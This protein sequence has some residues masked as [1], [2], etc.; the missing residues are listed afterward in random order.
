[1][2]LAINKQVKRVYKTV[3]T[4]SSIGI[5]VQIIDFGIQFKIDWQTKEKVVSE[6][7]G[8]PILQQH[9]WIVFETPE[10]TDEFE[11]EDKPLWI[12]KT[13]NLSVGKDGSYIH[14]KSG[15]AALIGASNP[16]AE[17]LK[18]II[19]Y[20]VTITVGETSGGKPK[21]TAAMPCADKVVMGDDVVAKTDIVLYNDSLVYAI[22]DG[23]NEVYA[24]LPDWM[25]ENIDNQADA[26]KPK[27]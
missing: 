21:V 25:K 7:S 8:L 22:E 15:L 10:H 12:G 9:V 2:S 17:T 6:Y 14:E 5:P 19:G 23:K 20:P 18:D 1:M 16:Q 3:P 26:P 4:G 11:G 13:Y 27:F 24:N